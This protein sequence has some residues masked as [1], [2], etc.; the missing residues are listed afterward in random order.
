[1][2]LSLIF[3]LT[4]FFAEAKAETMRNSIACIGID[5]VFSDGRTVGQY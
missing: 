1:M 3:V 5:R 2:V 4:G